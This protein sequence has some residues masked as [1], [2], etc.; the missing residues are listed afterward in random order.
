MTHVGVAAHDGDV[1]TTDLPT[2]P[3]TPGA[4][5]DISAAASAETL[6]GMDRRVR[7]EGLMR[8]CVATLDEYAKP[9]AIGQVLGCKYDGRGDHQMVVAVD[10]AWAKHSDPAPAEYRA[11]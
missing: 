7:Y 6:L 5:S 9:T 11:A 8:C 1:S 2:A 3:V 10:G 4:A